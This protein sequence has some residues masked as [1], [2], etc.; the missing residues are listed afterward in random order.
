MGIDRWNA[1]AFAQLGCQIQSE[2]WD[3]PNDATTLTTRTGRGT[4]ASKGSVAQ[5]MSTPN[6]QI[7]Q[8]IQY[9]FAVYIH[10]LYD[11]QYITNYNLAVSLIWVPAPLS[12]KL[13]WFL[14]DPKPW[15]NH[16]LPG[17]VIR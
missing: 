5:I 6:A 17:L 8:L 14:G 13:S 4:S 1:V 15:Q 11:L 3:D 2:I 16:G 10:L 7:P 9:E 12:V